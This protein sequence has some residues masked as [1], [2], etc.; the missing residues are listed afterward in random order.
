[1]QIITRR[2]LARN[3]GK[4]GF[5]LVEV[6][7]V[8][9]ILAI[10]AAI[11]IPALTGYIDKAR[12]RSLI[13]EARNIRVAL[14]TIATEEYAE[15]HVPRGYYLG[16]PSNPAQ[17]SFFGTISIGYIYEYTNTTTFTDEVNRLNGTNLTDSATSGD[18][19]INTIIITGINKLT[20]VQ[21]EKGTKKVVYEND[22]Y[23]VSD[24]P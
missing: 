22:K 17:T 24:L 16:T 2:M 19:R 9:V 5:T 12:D 1:M 4:K 20:F 21:F 8:L 11:A 13:A 3:N 7:V 15:G 6:I 18:G 10:L 23:T 14:L